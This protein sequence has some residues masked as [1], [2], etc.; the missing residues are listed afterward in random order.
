MKKVVS[1]NL[2]KEDHYKSMFIEDIHIVDGTYLTKA[3]TL[4]F[5]SSFFVIL[6]IGSKVLIHDELLAIGG[7]AIAV[8]ELIN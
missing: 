1:K 6:P 2:S 5:W 7:T 8:A 3:N 4:R